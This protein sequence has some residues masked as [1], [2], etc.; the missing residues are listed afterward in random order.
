MILNPNIILITRV[1][2]L[3]GG[4][5]FPIVKHRNTHTAECC[6]YTLP[7]VLQPAM[8]GEPFDHG[9]DLRLPQ[10]GMLNQISVTH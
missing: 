4:G 2:K 7:L 8:T 5:Q 1:L 3:A 10:D 6:T 9:L